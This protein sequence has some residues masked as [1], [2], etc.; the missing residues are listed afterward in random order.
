MYTLEIDR[1]QSRPYMSA[2]IT[3]LE[4]YGER[5]SQLEVDLLNWLED[6]EVKEFAEK[7]YDIEFLEEEE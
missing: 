3:W 1:T 6:D 7:N 5:L 2:F 4:V